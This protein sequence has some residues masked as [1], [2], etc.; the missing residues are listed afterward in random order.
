[1]PQIEGRG[2]TKPEYAPIFMGA[3]LVLMITDKANRLNWTRLEFTAEEF[4]ALFDLYA[5]WLH[6]SEQPKALAALTEKGK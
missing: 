6:A 4:G 1:M 5:D 2:I 3:K